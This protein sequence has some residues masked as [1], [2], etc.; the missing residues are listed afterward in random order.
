MKPVNTTWRERREHW[1]VPA[2]VAVVAGL[3]M[4][5]LARGVTLP[6]GPFGEPKSGRAQGVE[7]GVGTPAL[8]ITRTEWLP[9]GSEARDRLRLLDPTPL[10][11][12]GKW[13]IEVEAGVPQLEDRPGGEVASPFPPALA[14]SEV[15][16]AR[17]VLVP[18]PVGTPQEAASLVTASRWFRGMAKTDVQP[19]ADAGGGMTGRV[20]VYLVGGV[21][22]VRAFAYES[23]AVASEAPWRPMELQVLV[24]VAGEVVAPMVKTSSGLE[25]VDERICEL[26]RTEWLPR[27]ALRPGSYLFVVGP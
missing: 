25:V 7:R 11:M 21:A 17:E 5:V 19:V 1:W 24:N 20:D 3:T 2:V 26:T 10:F 4:F 16:P 6:A 12:P 15:R 27:L 23:G 9:E 18:S 14:F 8:A 22:P 13:K